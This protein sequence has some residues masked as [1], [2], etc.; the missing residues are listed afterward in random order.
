V[1]RAIAQETLDIDGEL[2]R[3]HVAGREMRET[4]DLLQARMRHQ[5]DQREQR[6]R[7]QRPRPGYTEPGEWRHGDPPLQRPAYFDR[8]A[9]ERQL[10]RHKAFTASELTPDEAA[11][12]LDQLDYEFHL[13]RDLASGED[14][15]IERLPDHSYRLTRLHATTIEPEPV[16]VPLVIADVAASE[17]TVDEALEGLEAG[18]ERFGSSPTRRRTAAASSTS[19]TTATTG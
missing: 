4:V 13:Y 10:V 5:L 17:L 9:A 18:H 7:A 12:D 16:S 8:P 6:R 1:R 3:A 2:V 15:L 11:F 14:A 19:A